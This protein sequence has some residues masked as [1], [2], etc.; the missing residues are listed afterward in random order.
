M[1]SHDFK[2]GLDFMKPWCVSA[3]DQL[4]H[5]GSRVS[6]QPI[7]EKCIH[8]GEQNETKSNS[9]QRNILIFF[10]YNGLFIFV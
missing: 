6:V 2:L 7:H 5:L 4:G 9:F 3:S 1:S 10:W 8:F